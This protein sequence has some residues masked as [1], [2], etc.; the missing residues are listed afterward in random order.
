MSFLTCPVFHLK[1]LG[2]LRFYVVEAGGQL[3]EPVT[4]VLVVYSVGAGSGSAGDL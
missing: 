3:V 1:H 4:V 2:S